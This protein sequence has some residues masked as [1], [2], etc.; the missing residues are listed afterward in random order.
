LKGRVIGKGK[1]NEERDKDEGRT[2]LARYNKKSVVQRK[3]KCD[4]G[5]RD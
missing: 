3:Q 2:I 4:S 5:V 1:N